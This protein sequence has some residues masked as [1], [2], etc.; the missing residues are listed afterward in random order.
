MRAAKGGWPGRALG[1]VNLSVLP[2][3]FAR[4]SGSYLPLPLLTNGLDCSKM[5]RTNPS[6]G[7]GCAGEKRQRG[8]AGSAVLPK[9]VRPPCASQRPPTAAPSAPA[10]G[11]ASRR[12]GR[13]EPGGR[14]VN[15]PGAAAAKGGRKGE[16]RSLPPQ[17]VRGVCVRGSA[18]RAVRV[19]EAEGQQPP[20]PPGP[21]AVP[22][23]LPSAL[24][25]NRASRSPRRAGRL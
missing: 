22:P 10:R 11:G 24:G 19:W 3:P 18:H 20:P 7:G 2:L 9:G 13:G 16:S 14:R 8:V 21:S 4:G 15:G 12:H 1:V 25:G 5:E 17:S 6:M 23:A